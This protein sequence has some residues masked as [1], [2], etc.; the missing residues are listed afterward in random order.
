MHTSKRYEKNN[1]SPNAESRQTN[2]SLKWYDVTSQS[3]LPTRLVF[4]T[5]YHPRKRFVS[6]D[7][8]L[9]LDSITLWTPGTLGSCHRCNQINSVCHWSC[10]RLSFLCFWVD[11]QVEAWVDDWIDDWAEDWVDDWVED[12]VDDWV[13]DW[14]DDLI[15][16]W[17]DDWVEDWV[18][19]WVEDWVDDWVEDW[20]EDWVD[21]W[22]EDWVDDWV[23]DWEEDWVDDWVEDWVDDWVDGLGLFVGLLLSLSS[24]VL[25]L[26]KAAN[27]CWLMVRLMTIPER[28]CHI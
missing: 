9:V 28:V 3:R 23:E 14:V 25:F 6:L 12:W 1:H 13:E 15:E 11:D 17:V 22:V 26:K 18:D 2:L 19:D 10:Y 21:D 8:T 4:V 7:P 16:D 5:S 27:F 20:V 24:H